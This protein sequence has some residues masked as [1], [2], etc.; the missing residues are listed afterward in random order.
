MNSS[1]ENT[2]LSF[3]RLLFFSD[4]VFAIVITLLVLELRVPHIEKEHLTDA[5]IRHALA[6]L[7]PKFLGF[8]YSFFIVGMMWIEHHRI[9]RFIGH[10]NMGLI[11]RNLLF[12]LF[13]AFIPFPTAL[14]SE[15]FSSQTAFILYVSGFGLAALAKIWI[16]SYAVK[17]RV[18]L[19]VSDVDDEMI[20]RISRRSWAV[21]I[22]CG[23]AIGLS[24][25]AIGFGGLCFPLIPL[26]A[27]LLYPNKRAAADIKPNEV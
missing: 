19:L 27:H 20:K 22:V 9:F 17:N 18:E 13:V 11:V 7:M 26:V 2:T 16:W 3:E 23:L 6:E 14:F 8:I 12:L 5:N 24:F 10:Y 4:A 1:H 21:P 25:I 15:Y